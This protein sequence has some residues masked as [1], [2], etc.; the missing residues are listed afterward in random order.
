MADDD[1]Q[2]HFVLYYYTPNTGAAVLFII[3][4]GAATI[5]HIV[6][7][8]RFKMWFWTAFI[9]GSGIEAIGYIG[10]LLGHNNNTALGPFILQSTLLLVAPALFAASIYMTLGRISLRTSTSHLLPI[11]Q[12]WLTLTFVCGDIL[13]FLVQASGAGILAMK[14]NNSV[15]LGQDVIL[16]GLGIQIFWFGVFVIVAWKFHRRVD[17]F[18]LAEREGQVGHP[19]EALPWKKLMVTLYVASGL[20][21]VRSVFRVVEYGMGNSGYLM[22][23][24]AF[25]YVFDSTLMFLVTA[26]F[27][28][29]HPSEVLVKE[30]KTGYRMERFET[31]GESVQ[32]IKVSSEAQR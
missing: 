28:W 27:L 19:A 3:L 10:R 9:I 6:Q 23:H 21:L 4:F 31:R 17:A 7:M 29:V 11:R 2:H 13:S 26:F 24:E 1:G 25:L 20:I 18:L 32:P 8:F 15:S 14:N 16:T 12:R 22:K 5:G 30:G